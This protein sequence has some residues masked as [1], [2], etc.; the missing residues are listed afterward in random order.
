MPRT[1][2]AIGDVIEIAVAGGLAYAQYTHK[3]PRY[4]A[5]IRVLPGVFRGRPERLSDIVEGQT[6]FLTFFPLGAAS[7][8]HLVTIVG[9]FPSPEECRSF[10]LFRTGVENPS[11]RKVGDNGWLWDGEREWR[12]GSLTAEQRRLPIRGI[13]NDTLLTERILSGW[14]SEADL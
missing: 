4:G 2:P 6:Q 11:T 14:R 3:H 13:I 5:L 9:S 7:A 10:P 1:R 12:V 8:R